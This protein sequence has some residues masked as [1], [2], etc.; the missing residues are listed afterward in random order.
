MIKILVSLTF[1]STLTLSKQS[2]HNVQS[3]ISHGM[4]GHKHGIKLGCEKG[5]DCNM[6]QQCV[7]AVCI[8]N[9]ALAELVKVYLPREL[10]VQTQYRR[11]NPQCKTVYDCPNGF[12]KCSMGHCMNNYKTAQLQSSIKSAYDKY[13]DSIYEESPKVMGEDMTCVT[14]MQCIAGHECHKGLCRQIIEH[15]NS[16][17]QKQYPKKEKTFM[18][19]DDDYYY[20][21]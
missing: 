11:Q 15:E 6:N 18:G 20:Q 2:Q 1:L 4:P 16:H 9:E 14:Q 21:N 12:D 17:H 19:Y 13:S 5:S 3:E 10:T 7:R 8:D